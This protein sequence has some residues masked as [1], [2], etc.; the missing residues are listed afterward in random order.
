MSCQRHFVFSTTYRKPVLKGEIAT[1]VRALIREIPI[2]L[3][4]TAS[5]VVVAILALS[6]SVGGREA[7]S[8]RRGL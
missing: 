5:L 2:P 1:D 3:M 7:R 8:R 4:V 6:D